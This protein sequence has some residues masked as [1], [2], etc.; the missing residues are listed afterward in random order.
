M[1][2]Y[3]LLQIKLC[4]S[5]VPG[6]GGPRGGPV[7]GSPR[8]GPRGGGPGRGGAAPRGSAPM[9][10]AARGRGGGGMASAQSS[11]YDDYGYADSRVSVAMVSGGEGVGC[12]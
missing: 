12:G 7:R 9:R 10:G 5:G 11:S 6:R 3:C 2:L 4:S 1:S 8:G